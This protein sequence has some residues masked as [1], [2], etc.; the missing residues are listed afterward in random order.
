MTILTD[1]PV[2]TSGN[3]KRNPDR[4]D[5]RDAPGHNLPDLMI[6]TTSQIPRMVAMI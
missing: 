6:D 2:R 3:L 4:S 1:R 5:R